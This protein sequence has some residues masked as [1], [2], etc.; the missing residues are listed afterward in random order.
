M[1]SIELTAKS[2]DEG[3]KQAAEKLG[4]A[5]DRVELKVLEE[6][7]GLFGRPSLKLSAT[8]L[9]SSTP[10]AAP[11][12]AAPASAASGDGSEEV[13]TK[14]KTARARTKKAADPAPE[15][16]PAA[17][18]PTHAEA[19]TLETSATEAPSTG[20]APRRLGKKLSPPAPTPAAP[21]PAAPTPPAATSAPSKPA[22]AESDA[23]APARP[24]RGRRDEAPKAAPTAAAPAPA[25]SAPEGDEDG[26]QATDEDAERYRALLQGLLVTSGL[27]VELH[28]VDIQGKYVNLRIDDVPSDDEEKQGDASYLIGRSGEV[29][30]ALQ[31]L[32]NLIGKQQFSDGV[33]VV[34]DGNDWRE[35]REEKLQ[36]YTLEIVAAVKERGEEA[37][38][39]ALPAFERRIVHRIV[40]DI[41]GVQTY[42]EGEE[43]NRRVVIAPV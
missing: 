43:P 22:G 17:T 2:L 18:E 11:A 5:P 28:V 8:V 16:T 1:E 4:V 14:P 30:N 26:V 38:L 23:E 27:Q 29:L 25:T 36:A 24:A 42:S 39:D 19:K 34:L 37:L 20:S 10:P 7:K 15:E 32:A 13:A 31:Y 6:G 9:A 40:Q 35:K 33:R 12:S 3:R 21:T 41:D